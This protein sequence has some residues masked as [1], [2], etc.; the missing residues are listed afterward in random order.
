MKIL[1]CALYLLQDNNKQQEN[2]MKKILLATVVVLSVTQNSHAIIK[3]AVTGER[4][5]AEVGGGYISC[6]E[7]ITFSSIPTAIIQSYEQLSNEDKA[8]F[9]R[10]EAIN[11]LEGVTT[12]SL[13]LNNI[14]EKTNKDIYEVAREILA[15]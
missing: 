13:F 1:S 2:F 3:S 6:A 7:M 14:A 9:L 15:E 10:A 8:E 5:R 12:E 11:L 4:C